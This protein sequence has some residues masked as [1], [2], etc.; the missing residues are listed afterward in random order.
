[1]LLGNSQV[2]AGQV[3]THLATGPSRI[4]VIPT[5]CYLETQRYLADVLFH[6]ASVQHNPTRGNSIAEHSMR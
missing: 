5:V 4:H 6:V 3:N 1:V 2:D